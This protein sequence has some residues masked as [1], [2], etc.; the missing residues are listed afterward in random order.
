[1]CVTGTE[2]LSERSLSK[3]RSHAEECGKP[4]PEDGAGTAHGNGC[5]NAGEVAGADLCGNRS[6]ERLEGT[7]T[8]LAC[9]VAKECDAAEDLA[10]GL[11]EAADLNE[12]QLDG[13][14]NA[15][16]HQKRD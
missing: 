9:F 3:D 8:V 1:M 15:S 12:T 6:G 2:Y 4:H 11:S 13:E 7:H 10:E 16:A 14:I 5:G